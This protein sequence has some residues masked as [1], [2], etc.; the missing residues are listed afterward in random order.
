MAQMGE[1]GGLDEKREKGVSQDFF[2]FCH[3]IQQFD[4]GS[5]FSDQ[6]FNTGC[7]GESAKS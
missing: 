4:V 1:E 3:I 6:G 5:Q 7:S 2:F